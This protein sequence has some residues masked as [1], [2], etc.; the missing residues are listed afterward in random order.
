[1]SLRDD[2]LRPPNAEELRVL[3]ACRQRRR[4]QQ[5]ITQSAANPVPAAKPAVPMKTVVRG[6][7]SL[8]KMKQTYFIE[9]EW[10]REAKRW[11]LFSF[12]D[13]LAVLKGFPYNEHQALFQQMGY[14]EWK[15]EKFTRQVPIKTNEPL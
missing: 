10:N 4:P 6:L 14:H 2:V 9:Y 5:T 3:E 12:P 1:M 7:V 13:H 15:R 8:C 11:E